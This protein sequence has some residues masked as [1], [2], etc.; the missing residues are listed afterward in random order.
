MFLKKESTDIGGNQIEMNELSGLQ[1]IEYLEYLT[2]IQKESKSFAELPAEERGAKYL[3]LSLNINAW[4]ISRSLWHNDHSKSVDDL[5]T[6]VLSSWSPDNMFLAAGKVL[7]LSNLNKAQ[8][9]ESD[10]ATEEK[11]QFSDED[12]N[13][14]AE[15]F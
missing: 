13:V 5:K 10:A 3:R 12:V 9:E 2:E 4:L 15:K 1:R 14:P 6:E 8:Q 7:S 11:S